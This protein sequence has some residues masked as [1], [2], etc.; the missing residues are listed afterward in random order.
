[1]EVQSLKFEVCPLEHRTRNIEY[2]MM[3]DARTKGVPNSIFVAMLRKSQKR[4]WN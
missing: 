2:R 3:N 1:L 4:I